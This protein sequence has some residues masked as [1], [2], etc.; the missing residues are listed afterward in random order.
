MYA[1][2]PCQMIGPVFEKM[3]SE[4]PGI[5]FVKV[6]VDDRASSTIVVNTI[7]SCWKT[8]VAL[9]LFVPTISTYERN[10]ATLHVRHFVYQLTRTNSQ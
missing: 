3:A 9:E 5:T 2:R 7:H 8:T 10:S 4:N 1:T 6:D